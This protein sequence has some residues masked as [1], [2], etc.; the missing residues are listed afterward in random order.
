M[1]ASFDILRK[2]WVPVLDAAG[3]KTELGLLETL[4]R[5]HELQAIQTAS[6][7]EE[8]SV[9]RF[10]IVF[11]MDALRPEDG[12]E[13]IGGLLEAEQFDMEAIQDYL[14]QCRKEGVSFNLFDAARPFCRRPMWKPGTGRQSRLRPWTIPFPTATTTSTLT[15]GEMRSA[16]RREKPC[17]CC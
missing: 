11:L 7:M 1:G 12:E 6:P 8:Y 9:Y 13:D 15:T 16:T 10:L 3:Q 14:T 4:E 2:P 17:G 5:A